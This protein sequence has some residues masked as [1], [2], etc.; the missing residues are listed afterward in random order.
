MPREF[1]FPDRVDAWTNLN[2]GGPM[3]PQQRRYLYYHTIGRMAGAVTIEETRR[4]F[5]QL[6]AQLAVEQPASNAGWNA[7]VVPFAGA[8]T[9]SSRTTC[10]RCLPPSAAS[11]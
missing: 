10:S 5:E 11:S 9:A 8:D 2:V 7:R 1:A 4:E 6:S 3:N